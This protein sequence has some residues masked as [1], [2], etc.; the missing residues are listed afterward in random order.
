MDQEKDIIPTSPLPVYS[1][2]SFSAAVDRI[3]RHNQSSIKF[4]ATLSS[5]VGATLS[6][7][8]SMGRIS[9]N[10]FSTCRFDGASLRRAAG[11]G[12]IFKDTSF[13]N[14]DLSHSTFQSSTFERCTFGGCTL[15]G[16]DMSDCHF[17]GTVWD[18][19]SYGA[20]NM[21]SA[22]F[23]ECIFLETKPGNLAEAVLENVR[24]ENVRL[25]NMNMEFSTFQNL[26][27]RNVILPFTQL[28]YIF[29]GLQYLI[30]TS[31]NVQVSS[32]INSSD[33]ISVD[34][35]CSV[36]KDMEIF[37]SH[38]QEYF[39]LAHIL[40]AFQRWDEALVATLLGL[41]EAALQRDF[42]MCKYYCKLITTNGHFPEKTLKELYQAICQASPT[43]DLSEAQY[44]QYLKHIPEIRTM[45]IENPNQYPR[46]TL[47][48]ETQ[49][50]GKNS[51]QTSALLSSLDRLLH[52]NGTALVHPSIT[53]SHNS[54][55]IFVI[56]LCGMP[57]GILAV[58]ALILNAISSVCKAYNNVADA[59]LKTQEIIKNCH[60][61]KRVELETRK[62][63]A[64]VVKIEQE[65]PGL[66]KELKQTQKQLKQCGI[67]I[68]D[69]SF[70]GQDF[71]PMKWLQRYT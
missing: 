61:V 59:I 56:S 23:K 5:A 57:L 68:A 48:I 65:N 38:R 51:D 31:D 36:L 70:D 63:S 29:G 67:V 15:Q 12:S 41:K 28:P 16:C 66:Q 58:G 46:A 24:L 2:E 9:H 52:L 27:T 3:L 33:S 42:R 11:S 7:D 20:A 22:R 55:E 10:Y 6:G 8:Y 45:L 32:H 4:K 34:E 44:Y 21:S 30:Q 47:R 35:Y 19:C 39:P 69:A 62:L 1:E 43:H 50:D 40:L 60:D 64:E 54:P 17:Q 25:T 53:V 26:S 13:A 71:D 14:T 49:I 18:R 37:Y